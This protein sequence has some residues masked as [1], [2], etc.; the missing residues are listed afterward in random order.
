V[1]EVTYD[2]RKSKSKLV[3]DPTYSRDFSMTELNTALQNVKCGKAAGPDGVYPEF[4]KNM[5]LITKKWLLKFMNECLRTG[6]LPRVWKHSRIV[7]IVKP[8]KDGSD[9]SHFRPI[10]LLC[11]I[12][13]LLERLLL[14][15][16]AA[17]IDAVVPIEQAGFRAGRS[18][19]EQVL[20]L[21][22]TIE[23][24][25]QRGSKFSA[26]FVDLSAAYDTVWRRGLLLKLSKVIPLFYKSG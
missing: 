6:R 4:I 18:C 11:V 12:N 15:R 26:A 20:A 13:K 1:R 19:C 25:F 23:S 3:D 22:S 5:G 17:S 7:A 2:L 8:G 9:P 16:I 14:Q 21:T 10:S 24:G